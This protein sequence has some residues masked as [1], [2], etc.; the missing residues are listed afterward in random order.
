MMI[1]L[2]KLEGNQKKHLINPLY[3]DICLIIYF[4]H[5]FIYSCIYIFMYMYI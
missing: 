3:T 2:V 1:W 4:I 5:L